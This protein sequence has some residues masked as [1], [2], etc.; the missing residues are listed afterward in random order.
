MATVATGAP[1]EDV[2]G[3]GRRLR[4]YMSDVWRSIRR[5]L[6]R[7]A[8]N[9]DTEAV[10]TRIDLEQ[11]KRDLD[12]KAQA[13]RFGSKGLPPQDATELDGPQSTLRAHIRTELGEGFRRANARLAR[14]WSALA[15]RDVSERVASL[16]QLA[17]RTQGRLQAETRQAKVELEQLETVRRKTRTELDE[18][19]ARFSLTRE[20]EF[21]TTIERRNLKTAVLFLALFQAVFNVMFFAQG[22]TYG[23][24]AGMFVAA[25]LGIADVT[26]HGLGGRGAAQVQAPGWHE[27]VFGS[28]LV[29]LLAGSVPAWNLAIV[30]LRNGVRM[31][32]FEVG[33]EEWLPN[34][35]ASPLGFIDFGSWALLVLGTLCSL[36]AVVAGWTWDEPIP[37]FRKLGGRLAETDEDI[38]DL[39]EELANLH[40]EAGEEQARA[41]ADLRDRITHDLRMI[42]TV[43]REV[44]A[45]HDNLVA[46]VTDARDAFHALIQFYRDENLLVRADVAQPPRY[47]QTVPVFDT[48][49]PQDLQGEID[50]MREFAR[51][52]YEIAGRLGIGSGGHAGAGR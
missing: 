23:M 7:D 4:L 35:I 34:L 28:A 46:H 2:E 26:L 32:G 25:V 20:P 36:S 27:K 51:R 14:L 1:R 21:R 43:V 50:E 11:V 18:Y 22:A 49:L 6:R 5:F 33:M 45:M 40:D 3:G 19:K 37:R 38:E 30:H 12:L 39:R 52:Q 44:D 31:H 48:T 16:E 41:E 13:H 17:G 15:A 47:F 9:P 10:F 8:F 42:D 29:I 24:A